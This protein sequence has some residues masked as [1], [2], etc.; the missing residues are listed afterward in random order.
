MFPEEF[1]ETEQDLLLLFLANYING[2]EESFDSVPSSDDETVVGTAIDV[3]A[4]T[5]TKILEF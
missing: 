4:E 3:T 2:T 5:S 1:T